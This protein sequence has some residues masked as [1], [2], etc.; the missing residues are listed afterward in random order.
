MTEPTMLKP[1]RRYR[2]L[3]FV[4]D[5]DANYRHKL[6]SL[7]FVPGTTFKT[8]RVAP[9]GDP[10]E[11]KIKGFCLSLRQEEARILHVEELSCR[12]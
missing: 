9:L 4:P 12:A 2:L 10:L 1:Q 5:A 7:G 3:G 8:L 11:I 6:L